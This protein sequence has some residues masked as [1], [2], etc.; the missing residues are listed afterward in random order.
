MDD[1]VAKSCLD[2]VE[3]MVLVLDVKG[4]IALINRKGCEILGYKEKD[5]LGKNW[6]NSFI[7]EKDKKNVRIVFDKLMK[8]HV[9]LVKYN[10][11]PIVTKNG[12]RMILWHNIMLKDDSGKASRIISSGQDVTEKM[13]AEKEMRESEEKYKD[14]FQH[15]SDAMMTMGPSSWKFMSGNQAALKL[16]NVKSEKQFKSLTPWDLFP[17]KQP[18]GQLS[19]EKAK[20][21]IGKT[22]K[23]G[24]NYFQWVHKT[25]DGKN[26]PCVV[27]LTKGKLGEKTL[28]QATVK[29]IS[30]ERKES[31]E[32]EKF[33]QF[34]VN[35]EIKMIELKGEINDLLKKLGEKPKYKENKNV[36]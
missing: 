12:E 4:E 33:N 9:K 10:K 2:V 25:L 27:F 7:P 16:F 28:L 14:L 3:V 32:L 36:V 30:K 5:L 26:F 13:E 18:D 31:E 17:K 19:T 35:R 23:S 24:S 8:G 1:Q 11:N 15:S 20:V 21:E 34:A 22:M 6:I 29:D